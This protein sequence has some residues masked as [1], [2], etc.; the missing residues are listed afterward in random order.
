MHNTQFTYRF[1]INNNFF[2]L[3]TFALLFVYAILPFFNSSISLLMFW[4][5]YYASKSTVCCSLLC[6]LVLW[7]V[8]IETLVWMQTI[9]MEGE[10]IFMNLLW[11]GN[12]DMSE[13]FI[14]NNNF[15]YYHYSFKW[16]TN[17]NTLSKCGK[18]GT[19]D[20]RQK[21]SNIYFGEISTFNCRRDGISQQQKY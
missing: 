21:C 13:L 9:I 16:L 6:A 8:P 5:E 14:I 19:S 2:S 7:N 11:I 12:R 15:F 20:R 4:R 18:N 10:I 3:L 17:E 1:T